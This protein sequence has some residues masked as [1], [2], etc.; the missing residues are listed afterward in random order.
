MLKVKK[1]VGSILSSNMYIMF[2]EN[3]SACWII[4]VGDFHALKEVLPASVCVKGLFLTHGHFDHIAGIN[5][6]HKSYPKA[7][8]YTSEYGKEQ[9]FSDKKNFSLYHE[10]SIVF[11]EN[12]NVIHLLRH[13]DEIELYENCI[14]RII[15]TPGHCPSCLTY[16]TTEYI[17]TGDSYIPNAQVVTKLPLG[18]KSSANESLSIIHSLSENRIIC[19]GHDCDKWK[20]YFD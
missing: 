7:V 16:F 4:D 2:E 3:S 18:N 19:A 9:L 11:Q 8:I 12:E 13:E 15:A 10:K 14:L 5:D 1:V 6:F 17:F 20:S